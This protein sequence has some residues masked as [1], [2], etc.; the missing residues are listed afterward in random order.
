MI[1]DNKIQIGS[2]CFI[3]S[4]IRGFFFKDDQYNILLK[5]GARITASPQDVS[6]IRKA[7]RKENKELKL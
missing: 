6:V 5:N 7:L 1:L 4:D 3:L 2:V